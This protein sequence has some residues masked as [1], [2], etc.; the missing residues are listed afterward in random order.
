MSRYRPDLQHTVEGV[1]MIG[2]LTEDARL[3]EASRSK[4]DYKLVLCASY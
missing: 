3:Q 1:Y 4:V 2:W